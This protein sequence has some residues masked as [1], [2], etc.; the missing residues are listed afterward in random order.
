MLS[1]TYR[2][3]FID[4]TDFEQTVYMQYNKLFN[5][6][7]AFLIKRSYTKSLTN[8]IRK[9]IRAK[10]LANIHASINHKLIPTITR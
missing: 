4:Q 7:V 10:V 6:N 1:G 9:N 2:S 5:I 3:K 8:K